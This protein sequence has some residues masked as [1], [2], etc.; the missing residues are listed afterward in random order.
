MIAVIGAF[1]GFHA[2]HHLLLKEAER[3]AYSSKAGW[4]VVTFFPHPNVYFNRNVKLL[5][6]EYEKY[7]EAKFLK[8]PEVIKLPFKQ[9]C[10]MQS[11]DFLEMLKKKYSV[12]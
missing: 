2:G 7:A 6:S 1:D 10:N 11:E 12:G 8:I 5:F 9:I 3:L 4:A